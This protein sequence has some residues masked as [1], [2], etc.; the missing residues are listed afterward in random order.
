MTRRPTAAGFQP[1]VLANDPRQDQPF[2]T[3]R[4]GGVAFGP[5]F[6]RNPR[7]AGKE[8]M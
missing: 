4:A 8:V 7:T 2:R 5:V 1:R 3:E 6:Y